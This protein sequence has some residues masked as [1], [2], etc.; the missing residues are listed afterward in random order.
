MPSLKTKKLFTAVRPARVACL[1]N[2]D[3]G[4][5]QQ[6]CMRIIEFF[7]RVWGG[8]HNIIVPTDGNGLT[9]KFWKILE[10]YDADYIYYYLHTGTDF[11]LRNPEEYRARLEAEVKN[12]LNGQP[13][14][15]EEQARNYVDGLLQHEVFTPRPTPEFGEAIRHRLA[16]FHLPGDVINGL[17]SD[18]PVRYPLTSIPTVLRGCDDKPK[19]GV[20]EPAR[21]AIYPL[22]LASVFGSA[23]DGL[24]DDLSSFYT[25]LFS[26]VGRRLR[27]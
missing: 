17:S 16:P 1:V 24:H 15:D 23:S 25:F 19:I 14:H 7:S 26:A 6:T 5:W 12:Y 9:E 27:D 13:F 20:F 11:K 2:Q 4:D 8:A 18:M 22:W 10:A 3:D 21:S